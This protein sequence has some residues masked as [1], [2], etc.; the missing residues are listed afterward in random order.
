MLLCR[1]FSFRQSVIKLR[2]GLFGRKALKVAPN[3]VAQIDNLSLE[4][5]HGV[6]HF[7][8]SLLRSAERLVLDAGIGQ[9]R[10]HCDSRVD[11]PFDGKA[12]FL[13]QIFPTSI[14]RFL[15]SCSLFLVL[16]ELL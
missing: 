9:L 5:R 1:L 7:M 12:K 11:V 10:K 15:L 2:S 4:C 8:D 13:Q 14:P 6:G 16:A 3:R